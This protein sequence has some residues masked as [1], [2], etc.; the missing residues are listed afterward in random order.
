MSSEIRLARVNLADHTVV[1]SEMS[2]SG[3]RCV[4]STV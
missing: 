3:P 1:V 2:L 4:A